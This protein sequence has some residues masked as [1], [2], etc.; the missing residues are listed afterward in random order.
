MRPWGAARGPGG[1]DQADGENPKA[2]E[3]GY[4]QV[5]AEHGPPEDRAHRRLGQA[6]RGRGRH[7]RGAQLPGVEELGQRGGE[8]GE[9]GGDRQARAGGHPAHGAGEQDR[10]KQ[11][12]RAAK[13]GA[14]NGGP[15]R[16][17]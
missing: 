14:D 12:G 1:D 2:S 3:P 8:H 5:L 16:R 6:E 7:R 13:D 10:Q 4:G 15:R 9:V 17:W 11:D